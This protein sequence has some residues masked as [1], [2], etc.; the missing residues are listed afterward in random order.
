MD[1]VFAL[2]PVQCATTYVEIGMAGFDVIA[3][4]FVRQVEFAAGL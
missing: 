2:C 4:E 3:K 1:I